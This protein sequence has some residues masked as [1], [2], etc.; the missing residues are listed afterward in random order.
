MP[1]FVNR[2]PLIPGPGQIVGMVGNGGAKPPPDGLI[3]RAAAGVYASRLRNKTKPATTTIIAYP[4]NTA[5]PVHDENI[6]PLTP[7]GDAEFRCGAWLTVQIQ[8]WRPGSHFVD[9]G[10]ATRAVGKQVSR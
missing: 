4:Q 5:K 2:G 7:I 1:V 9:A 10:P 8:P 3:G 6:G